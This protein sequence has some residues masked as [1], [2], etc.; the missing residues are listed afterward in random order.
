M[1]AS[2]LRAPE[3]ADLVYSVESILSAAVAIK[4]HLNRIRPPPEKLERVTV[5]RLLNPGQAY[6]DVVHPLPEELDSFQKRMAGTGAHDIIERILHLPSEE[7]L[8]GRDSPGDP[9]LER[10][11]GKLDARLDL[12]DGAVLPVEI[13]N[14]AFA[15]DKPSSSHL[16]QLGMYCAILSTDRGLLFR[17]LRNDK[18]GAS[19]MLVPLEV[20]FRDTQAIRREM[21]RRRDLLT[22]AV[23]RRDPSALPACAYVGYKCKYREA[24][25][26]NCKERED[27]VP[28]IEAEASW[29]EAPD[30]L[31]KMK[32]QFEERVARAEAR[33]T[34]PRLSSYRLLTPRKTFFEYVAP[35]ATPPEG[36]PALQPPPVATEE[37]MEQAVG[38]VNTRGLEM[39][40]YSAIR[41]AN[42]RRYAESCPVDPA[43]GGVRT[44]MV[45][46]RPIHVKIRKVN[47][48]VRPSLRDVVGQWGVPDDI[49]RLAMESALVGA[50]Q[51]RIYVWNWKLTDPAMKLQVF[52]IKFQT[53]SLHALEAYVRSLPGRLEDALRNHDHRELPLCPRWMCQGCAFLERCH[54]DEPVPGTV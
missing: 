1:A 32:K 51:A 49:V 26:C 47:A 11:T 48:P 13:K 15:R 10:I 30:F 52:D 20:R 19:S 28:T 35:P 39:Q 14:V 37:P 6:Y 53:E 16:E 41:S 7:F 29:K 50:P 46:G 25:V 23:E 54:P 2:P 5:T 12:A 38:T 8:D 34:T 33:D 40:I 24:G 9:T 45:D 44:A 21:A 4:D 31:D 42:A 43:L 27:F 17:V 3:A 18:T 22:E 36:E